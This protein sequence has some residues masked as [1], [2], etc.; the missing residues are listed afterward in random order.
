MKKTLY[1]MRHGQTMF[2]L[3]K[4]NQGWSDSPLTK[5]GVKQAKFAAEYFEKN[6]INFDE[7][8]CSPSKRARTTLEIITN[9]HYKQLENL[10]EQYFGDLEGKKEKEKPSPPYSNFF[11]KFGGESQ[12]EFEDRINT[13]FRKIMLRD[14]RKVLV[15]THGGV[16]RHFINF[17]S[18]SKKVTWDM[19]ITNGCIIKFEFEDY[20]FQLANIINNDFS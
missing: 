7:I 19:K 5:V 20:N 9:S 11:V 8:Y 2:N 1:I 12:N 13:T 6:N 10:K 16:C 14:A 18:K 15:M 4:L 3:K 17:W